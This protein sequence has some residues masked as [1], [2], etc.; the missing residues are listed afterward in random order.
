MLEQLRAFTDV[1]SRYNSMLAGERRQAANGIYDIHTNV[2]H[3]PRNTQPTHARWERVPEPE[4]PVAPEES[5]SN[6]VFTNGPNGTSS[7]DDAAHTDG[8]GSAGPRQ[9]ENSDTIFPPIPPSI[10]RNFMVTD[11]VYV[12]PA[13][14]DMPYPG[15]DGQLMDEFDTSLSSVPQDIID[16]LDDQQR[17]DFLQA[18]EFER[19]WKSQWKTEREDKLR[20]ELN[21]SYNS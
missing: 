18:R 4:Q 5:R 14:P 11:I 3:Y 21:I 8:D 13:M 1:Q 16:L 6:P 7:S 15:P 2:M 12:S 19:Q 10:T 17:H 20:G 9:P